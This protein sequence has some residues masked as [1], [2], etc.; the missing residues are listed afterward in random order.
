M[1]N[2]AEQEEALRN[3]DAHNWQ[4]DYVLTHTAP[5]SIVAVIGD[6]P[7][8]IDDPSTGFLEWVYSEVGF[9]HW[10]FGHFH[11]N[12]DVGDKFTC[13]H[14]EIYELPQAES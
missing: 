11:K 6:S 3:L 5:R 4:V 9:K 12:A 1:P 10:Y 2:H 7:A 8:K 14:D 13:L